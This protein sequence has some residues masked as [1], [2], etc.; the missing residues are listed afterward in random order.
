MV[1]DNKLKLRIYSSSA[2]RSLL[3]IGDAWTL[4]IVRDAFRGVRRFGDWQLNL[5]I[6]KPV[7]SN[8]LSRLIREG[9]FERL[10]LENSPGY[11]GYWLTDKGKDL[12][13]IFIAMWAWEQLWDKNPRDQRSKLIHVTCGSEIVPISSCGNCGL[14]VDAYS[15]EGR[16]IHTQDKLNSLVKR[17]QRRST[18]APRGINESV[19]KTQMTKIL[20]DRW[21]SEIVAA[22]FTGARRF[23]DFEERLDIS[24]AVLSHRLKEMVDQG[25]F[26]RSQYQAGPDRFAYRLSQKGRDLFPTILEIIRWGDRWLTG[27]S[28]ASMIIEHKAC[29]KNLRHNFCCSECGTVLNRRDLRLQFR[30]AII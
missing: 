28:G 5:G 21:I 3:I 1:N 29:G 2:V 18:L 23:S 24:P 11:K 19:I 6:A 12:W 8:R 16:L 20:G 27:T 14:P 17:W 13:S 25:I 30:D 15:T 26:D 10:P 22:A 9:I 4:R 7:L